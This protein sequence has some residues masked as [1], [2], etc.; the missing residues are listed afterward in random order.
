MLHALLDDPEVRANL[1]AEIDSFNV[2]IDAIDSELKGKLELSGR[3]GQQ[4]DA[5][6]AKKGT[7]RDRFDAVALDLRFARMAELWQSRAVAG[8]MMEDIRRAYEKERQ[9]ETLREAS[10]YLKRLTDGLYVNIW[11][12][13]GEDALFVDA[14]NGETLDVAALSRG[15]R[16]LLFI[17]IRLALVVSFEK[18]GV[19]MPLIWDDVLVNFDYRRAAIAAKLLFEFAKAGRQLF[20]RLGSPVCV[21]PTST[22]PKRRRFRVLTPLKK[23]IARGEAEL[24]VN[25]AKPV[26]LGPNFV[27]K[28]PVET[29]AAR[30]AVEGSDFDSLRYPTDVYADEPVLR[31]GPGYGLASPND[32]E[33]FT[34]DG[35][36]ADDAVAVVAKATGQGDYGVNPDAQNDERA[37]RADADLSETAGDAEI[38]AEAAD[39]AVSPATAIQASEPK[40]EEESPRLEVASPTFTTTEEENVGY[41]PVGRD[42]EFDGGVASLREL[43]ETSP[44]FTSKS[45]AKHAYEISA[46]LINPE[47]N[48]DE[49]VD[50]VQ[51]VDDGVDYVA[52]DESTFEDVDSPDFDEWTKVFAEQVKPDDEPTEDRFSDYFEDVSVEDESD[53]DEE[54]SDDDEEEVDDEYD[55]D[56]YEEEET[57]EYYDDEDEEEEGEEGEEE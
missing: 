27:E 14:A 15:T 8:Q 42:V 32:A 45:S 39:E 11:T 36:V 22:D 7:I 5:I 9:P 31:G 53:E 3:L 40:K 46:D 23:R 13:L 24:V 25:V 57:D 35:A 28:S 54:Y 47:S 1:P 48:P 52:V 38:V 21:L 17:A 30:F 16:E 10:R 19:Q 29:D 20:L 12:P 51:E 49:S 37:F 26:E 44:V 18:H 55:E 33:T 34:F 6:A 41:A 2:R 56:E 4:A 43:S 50:A